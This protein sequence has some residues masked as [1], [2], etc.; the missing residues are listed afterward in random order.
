MVHCLVIV[1][2]LTANGRN[3]YEKRGSKNMSNANLKAVIDLFMTN[4]L[5]SCMERCL[6][7][8]LISCYFPTFESIHACLVVSCLLLY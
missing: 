2:I 5:F 7:L 4:E 3:D 6:Y 1:C 8:Y